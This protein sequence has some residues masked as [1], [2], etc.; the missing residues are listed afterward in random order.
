MANCFM[1][2]AVLTAEQE[3]LVPAKTPG[4]DQFTF[5]PRC[6]PPGSRPAPALGSTAML[7]APARM[8]KG[9]G[10]DMFCKR[11]FRMTGAGTP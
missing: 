1:C 11:E 8:I 6:A 9:A 4:G 2:G 7:S 3:V 5:C 10:Q